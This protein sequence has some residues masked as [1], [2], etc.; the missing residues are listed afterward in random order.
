MK[1]QTGKRYLLTICPYWM[2]SERKLPAV[3]KITGVRRYKDYFFHYE[4]PLFDDSSYNR[5]KRELQ[6]A[7]IVE[8][9]PLLEELL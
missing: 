7:G 3:I 1:I 8:L 2:K 5:T 6:K 4:K 9:T